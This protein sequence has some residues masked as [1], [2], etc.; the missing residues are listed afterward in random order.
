MLN[1]VETA[2]HAACRRLPKIELV[3][4][5]LRR[6]GDLLHTRDALGKL[7]LHKVCELF[8]EAPRSGD[9]AQIIDCLVRRDEGTL[10][11][12]DAFE[13][14]PVFVAI[15]SAGNTERHP[16]FWRLSQL[17]RLI[18]TG[19]L[20][21]VRGRSGDGCS[22][23]SLAYQHWPDAGLIDVIYNLS[24]SDIMFVPTR[25]PRSNNFEAKRRSVFLGAIEALLHV[26][27]EE[28]VS[29]LLQ[30]TIRETIA[31]Q[32]PDLERAS[33][34]TIAAAFGRSDMARQLKTLR[35]HVMAHNMPIRKLLMADLLP[36]DGRFGSFASGLFRMN[37][38]GRSRSFVE[39]F[40]IEEHCDILASAQGEVSSMFVYLRDCVE[41]TGYLPFTRK[42]RRSRR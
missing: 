37:T 32:S 42:K 2:L 6:D 15:A 4:M 9:V 19:G 41:A 17:L 25:Y 22:A 27:S 34:R 14:T 40:T 8:A 23:L 33:A 20:N 38:V 7:P 26:S 1:T 39:S 18:R 10:S 21:A 16:S 12:R 28:F 31:R 13:E 29:P 24:P 30:A 11:H 5:L 36:N 35:A 3:E